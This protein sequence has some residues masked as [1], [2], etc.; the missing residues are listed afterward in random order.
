MWNLPFFLKGKH[1]ESELQLNSNFRVKFD[2][3]RQ[4]FRHI[5]PA[6]Q[7]LS[8]KLIV[9]WD[10]RIKSFFA[11]VRFFSLIYVGFSAILVN[12]YKIYV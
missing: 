3:R 6:L 1:R 5:F 2:Q 11:S 8:T 9:K 4:F 10:S 12:L 7:V